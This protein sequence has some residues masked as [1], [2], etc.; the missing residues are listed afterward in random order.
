MFRELVYKAQSAFGRMSRQRRMTLPAK[1]GITPKGR[2]LVSYL[3]LPLFGNPAS[4]RGHSNVWE[5][6]E[7]VS[8]LRRHG[9]TVD[10]IHWQDSSYSPTAAY[11]LVFD[12]HR[13]LLR[14]SGNLT[15]KVFHVT[16]S[17]PEFSNQAELH[18]LENLRSR[19]GV[20]LKQ[21][22][23][24]SGDDL[25]IFS[26]NLCAADLVTLIGNDVTAATF[27]SAIQH[28]IRRV[29]ATGS[30][31]SAQTTQISRGSRDE[32]IWFNGT[33][34]VHKGLDLV[35]EVFARNPLLT[36]HVVGPYAKEHDFMAAYHRELTA[37]PNI[38]S[39]GFLYPG[40]RRF[41]RIAS[42]VR[43][44]I[45]PTCSEGISTSSITC[46]QYGMIPVVSRQAG[47]SLPPGMG[48]M[49]E[50]CSLDELEQ[51]LRGLAALHPDDVALQGEAVRLHALESYSR[52][53]FSGCMEQALMFD[54]P[55]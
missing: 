23:G 15:R 1:G 53:G 16:G 51:S 3:T 7:I 13:N 29:N 10:L 28:K 11:D 24:I 36:L 44:F 47:I 52:Q 19:R 55:E 38:H 8:I 17:H 33:G 5:S 37:C 26:E 18:R 30:L 31:L 27:P 6:S 34:A 12:I 32:Y 4:F 14:Y 39:H 41:R 20:L 54:S 25:R 35:L 40:S 21:R 46:M 43:A 9:Y 42:K 49:L 22:R 50:E 2:A 48:A 45:N